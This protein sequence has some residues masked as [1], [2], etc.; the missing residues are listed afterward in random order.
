MKTHIFPFLVMLTTRLRTTVY[1]FRPLISSVLIPVNVESTA[2]LFCASVYPPNN[3]ALN[4]PEGGW[5]SRVGWL[6][7][8]CCGAFE[9]G[10]WSPL[11][12]VVCG[13]LEDWGK[14]SCLADDL[15]MRGWIRGGRMS[16][17][18]SPDDV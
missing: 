13:I 14:R 9:G 11:W 5:N 6:I 12:L 15:E 1:L 18:R 8:T 7:C 3:S 16:R 4:C 17:R 10:S 2:S